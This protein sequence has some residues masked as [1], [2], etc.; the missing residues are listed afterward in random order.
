MMRVKFVKMNGAGNDFV[1]IDNRDGRIRF[2]GG[3]IEALCDRRRGVGADGVLLIENEPGLDFRMR[4]YNRDGREAEM[5]GNGARCLAWF[6]AD[7]GLGSEKDGGISLRFGTVPGPMGAIVVGTRVTIEMTDATSMEKGV[8]L[9]LADRA[10]IVHVINTGVPH[11]VVEEHNVDAMADAEIVERGRQIR[12]HPRFAPNGT[13]VNFISR[14]GD[15]VNIRTYERGVEEETLACGTGAVAG[16][17]VAAE[18]GWAT[19]PVKLS[20]RGGEDLVVSFDSSP[21][22]ANKVRL[23]GP[24]AVNFQGSMELPVEGSANG[25]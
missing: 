2:N 1:T 13:N 19:S 22:G 20:T 17:V 10:E 8:S 21:G 15:S 25:V 14:A 11:A 23:A 4:Y 24:T 16:A 9:D 12:L 3:E 6:A 7:L 18:L 5:C